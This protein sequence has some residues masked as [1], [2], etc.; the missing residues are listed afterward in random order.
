MSTI[1]KEKQGR[2]LQWTKST[3]FVVAILLVYIGGFIAL[4]EHLKSRAI[5]Q[6]Q[7]QAFR[8]TQNLTTTSLN[9]LYEIQTQL[10]TIALL[11]HASEKVTEIEFLDA[12]E[13]FENRNVT[14]PITSWGVVQHKDDNVHKIAFSTDRI[15]QF[16]PDQAFGNHQ[17]TRNIIDQCL[18]LPDQVVI[19]SRLPSVAPPLAI[20]AISIP[21]NKQ[22]AV[23]FMALNIQ[24][25][26]IDLTTLFNPAGLSFHL[27][28]YPANNL[29]NAETDLFVS[30]SSNNKPV[31]KSYEFETEVESI[32]WKF[33][34]D[35][36]ADFLNGPKT[37]F[38]SII[39]WG[40]TVT[41]LAIIAFIGRLS[42]ENV[43]INN[44]VNIRTAEL[45]QA[46]KTAR[47][48]KNKMDALSRIDPLTGVANRRSLDSYFADEWK[49][50][51]RSKQSIAAIMIDIDFFKKYNDTLG[52]SAGDSCLKR[53]STLLL[54]E[55]NRGSD[56]LA[57]YGGEEFLCLCPET[58]HKGAVVIAEKLLRAVS[59]SNIPHPASTIT[60][61]V[62]VSIGAAAMIPSR[63]TSPQSLIEIADA[64]LY[65]AKNEGRNQ[66]CT[67]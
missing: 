19:S 24:E 8:E 54:N 53:I 25:Y 55:L 37:A 56:L 51:I 2:Q 12:I 65:K 13:Y 52:H 20:F 64:R 61:H 27:T 46:L 14:T 5:T 17:D 3:L 23:L 43:M 21:H 34:W 49:R 39:Q 67:E 38:A 9:L 32:H 35:V 33:H 11:F 22:T 15:G 63:R 6:W 66:V 7:Q 44:E 59:T 45:N 48:A 18:K 58:D 50:G 16:A 40:G 60:D 47:E 1:Q 36:H 31:L 10:K 28:K 29:D 26:F 4:G 57:R 30:H 62:T 42:K 41:G